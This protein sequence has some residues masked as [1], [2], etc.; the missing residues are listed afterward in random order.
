MRFFIDTANVEEIKK[1]NRMGF[2]AGVT[3]N[4]SLVAKEGRDFNE[5][6]QEI[7]SIVDGPISGEVVSLEADEM[8]AEGR[9]IAKI[10]PNMVVKIPMT[11]EGLAAVKVLTEEGI[12]T[13]VTLVFSATQALLAA[14][15]G[16]T[17]VSPFLGRLDDIGDDGLVL[18]RDIA[19]IFEIYGIPTEIIS[20]SV[21]HPIHVIE[22]AKAGADIA[23]VPFKVFEQMLKHP[24]TDS[25]IDKFLADWEAAKK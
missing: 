15:A 10:H 23:T 20:A 9:V 1:A 2:I 6:I 13:N 19:D 21:R 22:C 18:I 7:T 25:G 11:G 16:A 24:L 4:P 17:Y 12:K 8:I 14:R 5:V 3:T